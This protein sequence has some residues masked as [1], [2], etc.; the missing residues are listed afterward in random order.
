MIE[1]VATI[2]KETIV[3]HAAKEM[4]MRNIGSIL[5]I[6]DGKLVGILTEKD[7]LKK[8]V[9]LGKDANSMKVKDIM[10]D[11]VITISPNETVFKGSQIMHEKGIRRL[12]VSDDNNLYG[13]VTQT[14]IV[15]QV[16]KYEDYIKPQT[17]STR[18]RLM[19]KIST[20]YH[21]EEGSGY[22]FVEE[23]SSKVYDGFVSL[24]SQG[25][26]GLCVT[27]VMPEKIR[28]EYGLSKTTILWLTELVGGNTINPTELEKLKFTVKSFIK[29]ADKSVI[30]IDGV[31]YL[32]SYTSFKE[33]LHLLES[34]VDSVSVSKSIVLIG[35]DKETFENKEYHLIERGLFVIDET[36][37]KEEINKG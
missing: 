7:L 19:K 10:T 27:R 36:G 9:S 30:L 15:K 23:N 31:E 34:I 16:R 14:D 12:P 35:L 29:K 6:E 17:E 24:V 32:E 18:Q 1:N 28:E 4:S 2:S 13:I 33:V 26:A 20:D 37:K 8:V 11:K 21:L 3:T 25:Y 22:V 5:V